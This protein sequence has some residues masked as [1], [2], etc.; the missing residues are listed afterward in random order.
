LSLAD[1]KAEALAAAAEVGSMGIGLS[2][3]TVPAAGHP[4]FEL[5]DTG[6]ELSLGIHGEAGVARTLLQAA[7]R[8]VDLMLERICRRQEDSTQGARRIDGQQSRRHADDGDVYR[9]PARVG[10]SGRK[11][12]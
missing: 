5:G 8:L 12:H 4:G 6:I 11:G 7:D 2:A 3:R 9:R 1:V 10:L